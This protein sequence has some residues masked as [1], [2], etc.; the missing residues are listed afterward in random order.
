[1][2]HL[3]PQHNGPT[4]GKLKYWFGHLWLKLTG[5]KI[6]VQIPPEKKFIIVGAP[7]TSNWDFPIALVTCFALRLKVAWM[8]KHTL[9]K[10]PFGGFMRWL[11]GIPINRDSANGI[12][13]QMAAKFHESER[14]VVAIAAAGTRKK[15]EYWKS[16]FYWIAHEARVPILCGYLDYARKEAGLGLSFLPSGDIKKDMARIRAFY[17]N[18]SAKHPEKA[19]AIRI[20]DESEANH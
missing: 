5:W 1:M 4:S 2:Q 19:T 11:G 12:V 6:S 17:E 3:T 10:K 18:I 16:G 15:S 20:R 14:L 13:Q 9:F 8:G 7:H